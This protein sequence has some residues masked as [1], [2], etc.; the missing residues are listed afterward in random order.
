MLHGIDNYY[1]NYYCYLCVV[2]GSLN[3]VVQY[4]NTRLLSV[5]HV[6]AF[7]GRY[8][9]ILWCDNIHSAP[10]RRRSSVC[11]ETMN[12]RYYYGYYWYYQLHEHK[13]ENPISTV[14][15]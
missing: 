4:V 1:Y 9:I 7:A 3:F 15:L 13:G 8:N 6:Y 14:R 2:C 5:W 10:E 12:R 11:I